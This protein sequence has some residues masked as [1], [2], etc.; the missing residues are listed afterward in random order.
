M[1]VRM[2]V[3]QISKYI[4]TVLSN[5]WVMIIFSVTTKDNWKRFW[6]RF[7]TQSSIRKL[8]QFLLH[9]YYNRKYIIDGNN[10]ERIIPYIT[11]YQHIKYTNVLI[12]IY[13]V[14]YTRAFPEV[15][16]LTKKQTIWQNISLSLNI[17]S[18]KLDILFSAMPNS[19]DIL[20]VV[21]RR[22]P[23]KNDQPQSSPLHC[24]QIFWNKSER[25]KSGE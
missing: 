16:D 23:Q 21:N 22:V 5:C 25:A 19:F 13:Q 18:F 14:L 7:E 17:V 3:K 9:K 12:V 8:D 1:L 15:S 6:T 11:N 24:W 2:Y 20:F 4:K 10:P